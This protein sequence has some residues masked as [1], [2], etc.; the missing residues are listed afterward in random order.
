MTVPRWP[1]GCGAAPEP[2]AA[3][4]R[5]PDPALLV[6]GR[7]VTPQRAHGPGSPGW[8]GLRARTPGGGPTWFAGLVTPP[9]G[10]ARDVCV[11]TGLVVR[12]LDA[13]VRCDVA[14][15]GAAT[16][17]VEVPGI[18]DRYGASPT[19]ISGVA[20]PAVRAVRLEGPGGSFT[21]PLSAHREFLAVYAAGLR[22]RFR[23]VSLRADGRQVRSVRLPVPLR[24]YL[25]PHHLH[26]RS[27]AVFNDEIGENIV[28]LNYRQ[29][30]RRFGP[31]AARKGSCAYYELVG[32]ANRG[33]MFCFEPDGRMRSAGGFAHRPAS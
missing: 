5:A 31:P 25:R 22:G 30:V 29:I 24:V 26:R 6:I 13:N 27:G 33:W 32:Y 17:F 4:R 1:V 8:I 19:V 18:P 3:P 2:A 15:P 28:T 7:P 20:P 12:Q 11:S 9:R 16:S 23:V 14:V 10:R 21:L